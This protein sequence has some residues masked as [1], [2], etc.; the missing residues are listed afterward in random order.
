MDD[1]KVIPLV[2]FQQM[3][4]DNTKLQDQSKKVDELIQI[5]DYEEAFIIIKAIDKF[6]INKKRFYR[7]ICAANGVDEAQF[8]LAL[9]FLETGKNY[10]ML[11]LY[12][13]RLA[14][15]GYVKSFYPL[16]VCYIHGYGCKID[17]YEARELMLKAFIFRSYPDTMSSH[18]EFYS[19]VK[20]LF[21]EYADIKQARNY[22][23]GIDCGQNYQKSFTYFA[24]AFVKNGDAY[25]GCMLGKF[26]Q[27]GIGVKANCSVALELYKRCRWGII[28]CDY[29]DYFEMMPEYKIGMCLLDGIGT[30][31][32]K[33]FASYYLGC[34]ADYYKKPENEIPEKFVDE[35]N[36]AIDIADA[37]FREYGSDFEEEA[38]EWFD[39]QNEYVSY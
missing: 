8:E 22:F 39:I 26:Y 18:Y 30:P 5:G 10:D 17:L 15:K 12:L 24:A 11:Y 20:E 6:P 32:N 9:S 29:N 13:K 7:D 31:Q 25:A 36:S 34:V 35:I 38:E 23:Y 21:E 37:L 16:S 14:D 1:E 19:H 33:Q 3:I 4:F 28:S 2:E 27:D